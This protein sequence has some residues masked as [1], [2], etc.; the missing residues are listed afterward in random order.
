MFTLVETLYW[1]VD[2]KIGEHLHM[3]WLGKYNL[4]YLA[5][6]MYILIDPVAIHVTDKNDLVTFKII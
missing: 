3:I 5:I 4:S 2:Q 6:I 1:S